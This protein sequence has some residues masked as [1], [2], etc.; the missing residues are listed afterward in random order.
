M[1]IPAEVR[2]MNFVK[3]NEDTGCWIWT[4]HTGGSKGARPFFRPTSKS[5]DPKAYAHIWAYETW[6]GPRIEGLEFD[7]VVCSNRM[8]VN[9]FHLEQVTMKENNFRNRKKECINGHD[10]TLPEN[11]RFD[12]KGRRRGCLKCHR[13]RALKRYYANR[14]GS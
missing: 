12:E 2:F 5:T 4:G 11:Q 1:K 3:F 6:V 14:K 13:E 7:H 10:L 8:C 9:P